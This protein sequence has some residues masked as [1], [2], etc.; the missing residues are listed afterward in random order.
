MDRRLTQDSP[1]SQRLF[2][3]FECFEQPPFLVAQLSCHWDANITLQQVI[4]SQCDHL[5]S[6]I[7]QQIDIYSLLA[8]RNMREAIEFGVRGMM[9][10]QQLTDRASTLEQAIASWSGI[11]LTQEQLETALKENGCE[12]ELP[13]CLEGL[14]LSTACAHGC[15]VASR[16]LSQELLGQAR[17]AIARVSN[18]PD[19]IDEVFQR[20]REKL[21]TGSSPKIATYRGR[22]PLVA[23]LRMVARRIALDMMRAQK[24]GVEPTHDWVERLTGIESNSESKALQSRYAPVFKKA[25]TEVLESLNLEER[26]MLKMQLVENL[27]VAAIADLYNS[28]VATIYRRLEKCHA[29][30]LSAVRTRLRE[31]LGPVSQSE[32]Q[33]LFVSVEKEIGLSLTRLLSSETRE[34]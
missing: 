24:P 33:S 18:Q 11:S 16:T 23:W 14:A 4:L 8:A 29:N 17:G 22:G 30:L 5:G 9:S 27:S 13:T 12:N 31:E 32:I 2:T 34:A 21:L 19:F 3:V 10:E 26:T 6:A 15:S 1:C 7:S 20:V 28:H 25:L